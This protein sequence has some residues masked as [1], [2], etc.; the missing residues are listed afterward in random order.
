LTEPPQPQVQEDQEALQ[1]ATDFE[2][3]EAE[4]YVA[5]QWKLVWWRFRKHRLALVGTVVVILIYLIALFAEFVAPFTPDAFDA[6]YTYAPPQR[7]HFF[8]EDG[9]GLYVYG[10]SSKLNE[11]TLVRTF[12]VDESKKV[13][14]R[15]FAHGNTY[16]LW[17]LFES[18]L[19][20]IGPVEKGQPMYLL[21]ANDQGQDMLSR[22]IFGARVSMSIGLVGVA[23]SFVFGVLLGGISGYYAGATDTA[24][25]RLIEVLMS[26]PTLPLWLGLSAA[27]PPDWSPLR[28]YFGITIILSLIGWTDLARVVR[29]RFLSLRGED[30]VTAAELDGSSKPR[31]ILRH[32][33][34][35]FA[36]HVIASLTLAVPAMIL[37]ETA[38][39]FLG[40][41]LQPP[42]VSWGVLLQEAQNIRSVA[43]APWLL[44]PGFA[45]IIAVLA[46]NFMGDGLRDSADPYAR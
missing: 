43:T 19:H 8:D 7:L 22:I 37:A 34:P 2:E 25:Q 12:Q 14:V 6:D 32:M 45:V 9:F 31:I 13:P 1:R 38:L 10:Y 16:K 46:L 29:G 44:L 24:I 3:R 17:G 42:I 15:L 4:I 23:L 18:D 21:G 20:L 11:E 26:I 40:L 39:S 5:S 28:I 41:G 30:F 27:L 33:L 36:S 35:S